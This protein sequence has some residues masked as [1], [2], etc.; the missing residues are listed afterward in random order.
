MQPAR[1]AKTSFPTPTLLLHLS[2]L[3]L[4]A[5]GNSLSESHIGHHETTSAIVDL[6]VELNEPVSAS[7]DVLDLVNELEGVAERGESQNLVAMSEAKAP[8]RLRAAAVGDSLFAHGEA[9]QTLEQLQGYDW[10]NHGVIG[11]TTRNI[12][13]R[14]DEWG[15]ADY[16]DI[17]I[18]GGI[19]DMDERVPASWTI[20]NLREVYQRAGAVGARV[21]AVTCLPWRGNLDWSAEEQRDLDEVNAWILS[22]ADGLVD[23]T[24]DAFSALESEPGSDRLDP[25]YRQPDRL[26]LND[27]GQQRLA[28]AIF[29]AAYS[30]DSASGTD[31]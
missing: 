31:S 21:I 29:D 10:D 27:A 28:Q 30:A 20:E 14:A 23:V 24:V 19:N 11:N 7:P 5:C 17:V 8:A 12:L 4:A 16:A 3:A 6:S 25:L 2:L 9:V 13:N 26:H 18:L 15:R 22:G 1:S